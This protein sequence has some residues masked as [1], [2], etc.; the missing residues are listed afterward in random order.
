MTDDPRVEQ[1]LD[2]LLD[3][4][5]TARAALDGRSGGC[6]SSPVALAQQ[7]SHFLL[8][9]NN[10]FDEDDSSCADP[11]PGSLMDQLDQR[12][13]AKQVWSGLPITLLRISLMV[14]LGSIAC[15]PRLDCFPCA[16]RQRTA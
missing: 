10:L 12:A 15:P 7:K 8:W 4:N 2:E 16:P 11:G 9:R 13:R 6:A 14:I 1:L 5:A 3:P